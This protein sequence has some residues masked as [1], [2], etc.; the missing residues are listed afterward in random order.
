MTKTLIYYCQH[1]SCNR[2]LIQ[3]KEG[4]TRAFCSTRCRMRA[5]RHKQLMQKYEESIAWLR[6]RLAEID[7]DQ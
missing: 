2:E 7:A 3:A 1:H 4:R 6:Q 5:H